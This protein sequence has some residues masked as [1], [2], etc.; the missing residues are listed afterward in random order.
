LRRFLFPARGG[1]RVC[2]NETHSQGKGE[3]RKERKAPREEEKIF[4][5]MGEMP[6]VHG[7]E[8]KKKKWRS[9][10]TTGRERNA[11]EQIDN[12][13]KKTKRGR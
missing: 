1:W 7:K 8:K 10:N 2:G 11:H 5:E 13:E 9:L 3:G 4:S 12:W 6:F